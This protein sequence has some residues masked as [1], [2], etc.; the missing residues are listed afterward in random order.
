M[1]SFF[2]TLCLLAVGALSQ[3]QS[4]TSSAVAIVEPN[5]GYTQPINSLRQLDFK[6]FDFV[7]FDL[8]GQ[9]TRNI[10]LENGEYHE[11]GDQS[12]S[13]LTLGPVQYFGL[14]PLSVKNEPSYVLVTLREVDLGGGPADAAIVQVWKL[15]KRHLY[16]VQQ[17]TFDQQAPGAGVSFNAKPARLIIRARTNDDS[18]VCCPRSLDVVSFR[19]DG[20]QFKQQS[21]QTFTLPAAHK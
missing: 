16:I 11:R 15:E 3:P 14:G 18:P 2:F 6:N 17:F 20:R 13:D 21:A 19:W 8:N 12:G 4:Q 7:I 1:S 10:S 5:Y 9:P